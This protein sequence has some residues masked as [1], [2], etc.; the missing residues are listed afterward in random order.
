MKK[1]VSLGITF[2]SILLLSACNSNQSNSNTEELEKTIESL[3]IENTKLKEELGKDT[4]ENEK[5]DD[6]T[7][8]EEMV[9]DEVGNSYFGLDEEVVYRDETGKEYISTKIVNVSSNQSKFPDYMLSM[10]DYDTE[11]MVVV[12]IEYKNIGQDTPYGLSRSEFIA[13]DSTGKA[14]EQSM[15]QNGQDDV[16]K[17]RSSEAQIYWHVP[18]AKELNEIEID[19]SPYLDGSIG[20]PVTFKVPVEH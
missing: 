7:E 10:E 9:E 2:S 12:T 14:L 3:S 16:S 4:F 20:N 18:E 13:F 11:N 17:G 5:S 6:L 15:Q 1:M 19:Y 8:D